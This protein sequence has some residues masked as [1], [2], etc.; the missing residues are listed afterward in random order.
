MDHRDFGAD[1]DRKPSE[2]RSEREIE[3][4][5]VKAIEGHFIERNGLDD[6]ALSDK[7]HAV[8]SLQAC[9]RWTID[10]EHP[11]VKT[12]PVGRGLRQPAMQEGVAGGRP[13]AA[14]DLGCPDDSDDVERCARASD[15]RREIAGNNLDIV[16]AEE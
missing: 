11:D 3:V 8:E 13:I 16:V 14:Q 2:M 7:E 9:G 5:S 12:L 15:R 4:V 1:A 6:G 10:S